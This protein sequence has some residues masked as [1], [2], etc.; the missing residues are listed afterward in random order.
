MTPQEKLL[1]DD[2]CARVKERADQPRDAEVE[3]FLS[4]AARSQPH[5]LYVLAQ[6]VLV[7]QQALNEAA[8]KIHDLQTQQDDAR[9]APQTGSFLGNT[10][11][12]LVPEVPPRSSNSSQSG[13][14]N[15]S[16]PLSSQP[17]NAAWAAAPT[18]SGG[19][20]SGALGTM[21]G[22]AGGVLLA[23]AIGSMFRGPTSQAFMDQHPA[24]LMPTAPPM[25]VMDDISATFER[26]GGDHVS[27]HATAASFLADD[28]SF[29]ASGG[30]FDD[31]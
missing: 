31:V 13:W 6:Q 12:S 29:D 7:Q 5:I 3:A 11:S 20:L 23:D 19:F 22:V 4:D 30:S 21:A 16:A 27:D 1:L 17:A 14:G 25:S 15:V 28:S 2:L 24:S 9:P 26:N 18:Q 10:R 8:Q